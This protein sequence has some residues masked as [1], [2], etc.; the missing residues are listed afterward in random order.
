M[1]GSAQTNI[2][3]ISGSSAFARNARASFMGSKI[4]QS[5]GIE[6]DRLDAVHNAMLLRLIDDEAGASAPKDES[7]QLAAH[8]VA[9]ARVA[10]EASASGGSK[11]AMA[12]VMRESGRTVDPMIARNFLRLASS[13]IFWMALDSAGEAQAG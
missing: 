10:D 12:A 8:I 2:H 13:P 6:T 4:M 1:S 7:D 9:V 5:I 3:E 11:A